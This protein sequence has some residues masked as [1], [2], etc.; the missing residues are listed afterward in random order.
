MDGKKRVWNKSGVCS[1]PNRLA[2]TAQC[3]SSVRRDLLLTEQDI[4]S[5]PVFARSRRWARLFAAIVGSNYA[6]DMVV[7]L[8]RVFR[9]ALFWFITQQAAV[10]RNYHYSLRSNAEDRSSQL[11]RGGSGSQCSFYQVEVSATGRSLIQ[12]STTQ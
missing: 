8:L 12:N 9:N 6:Q 3:F 10:V 11:L 7:C 1:V 4:L 2:V 5:I